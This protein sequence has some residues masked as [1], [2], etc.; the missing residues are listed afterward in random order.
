M[1][2]IISF[3]NCSIHTFSNSAAS[4]FNKFTSVVYTGC[5][6]KINPLWYFSNFSAT[7]QKFLMKLCYYIL[8]SY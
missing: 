3:T 5:G 2:V 8:C 1:Y 7:D 4:L 6:K